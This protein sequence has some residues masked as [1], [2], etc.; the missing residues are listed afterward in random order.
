M[1]AAAHLPVVLLL[2]A[3]AL[4]LRS[5]PGRPARDRARAVAAARLPAVPPSPDPSADPR[6]RWVLAAVA[7]VATVLLVGGPV[8]PVAGAAVAV[9]LERALR[10]SAG[11]GAR[12]TRAALEDELPVACDLL[13]VC[14]AAGL[15]VGGALAAVAGAL[16]GPLGEELAVVAGRYRLGSAARAAWAGVPPPLA[17]LG[18]VLARAGESGSTVAAALHG[19]AADRR[20]VLR[21]GTEARVRRAGVW[22]LAPLGACFLPAFVCL[23]VAPVVLGIAADVL[24]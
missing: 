16:P 12:Q 23:G 8:G 2:V 14:L 5:P 21:A 4:L 11:S 22:V 18:R 3:A 20:A 24:P 9:G 17:G 7:G 6:R 1:S 13:A 10:R 19:L 15:P